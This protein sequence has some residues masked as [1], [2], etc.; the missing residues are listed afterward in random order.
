ME[1]ADETNANRGGC[2]NQSI[3]TAEFFRQAG[4]IRMTCSENRNTRDG[5][6][7]SNQFIKG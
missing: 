4:V 2:G 6:R 5:R 7:K 3:R 1:A